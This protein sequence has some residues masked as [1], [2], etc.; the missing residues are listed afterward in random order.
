MPYKNRNKQLTEGGYYHAYNR[1]HNRQQIFND[2]RDYKTFLYILKKYLDPEFRENK[3]IPSGEMVNVSVNN[4]LYEKIDLHA[5]V[6]MPNHYHI[7]VKQKTK[8]GMPELMKVLNGQYSSYFN[9]KYGSEGSI[10]Q[11]VYKAVHIKTEEQYLHVSRY[12]HLNP[13]SLGSDPKRVRPL[14]GYPYSSYPA[15]LGKVH[16]NWLQPY[17]ILHHFHSKHSDT[18]VSYQRFVE[19][20]SDLDNT[21]KEYEKSLI[22][23]LIIEKVL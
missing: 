12:I 18:E 7:L 13:H 10:W 6:V 22:N 3:L 17:D 1:G 5:F 4:P 21:Q 11:G 16:Y 19:G 15:F 8:Y 14:S 20:Y 23:D 2:E 9:E